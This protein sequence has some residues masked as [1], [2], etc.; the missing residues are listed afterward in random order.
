MKNVSPNHITIAFD[1]SISG[2]KQL[3]FFRIK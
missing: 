2:T 3:T 1:N